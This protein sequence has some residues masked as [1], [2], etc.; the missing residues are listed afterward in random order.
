[1]L[2]R[3][4]YHIILVIIISIVTLIINVLSFLSKGVSDYLYFFDLAYVIG[5]S[6]HFVAL[7]ISSSGI[8][9]K[10]EKISRSKSIPSKR[11]AN[12]DASSIYQKML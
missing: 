4:A 1:M 2:N 5:N 11:Y 3:Y 9:V 12:P 6:A 10:D 7:S 8:D